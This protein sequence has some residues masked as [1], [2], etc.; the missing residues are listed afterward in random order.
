MSTLS[1]SMPTL[2]D[3]A[4]RTDPDGKI[5]A[6]AMLLSQTNEILEDCVFTEGN[7]PTGHQE[8]IQTGLPEV[9][10]RSLN[11]GI[12][13]SK[14]T[15]A[16]ITE[17]CSMLEARGEIDVK[18]AAL[19]DN[20]SSFRLSENK[21]FI[22]AMNQQMAETMFYGNPQTSPKQH[23]GLATRYSD[24]SAGNAENILD[25]G[26]TGSDNTSIYIVGW[27]N[28]TVFC[29]Y[30]KG[31]QAGLVH[32]DLG[33]QTVHKADG[34]RLQALEDLYCWDSGLCVKD[35]RYA[36]RI[37]NI[38]VSDLAA[39]TGT[40]APTAST[41]IVAL[42]EQAIDLFPELNSVR[43]VAYTNRAV[44][45]GLRSL[46]RQMSADV[47]S[48]ESGFN[49]FGRPHSTMKFQELALRKCDKILK[50]ESRVT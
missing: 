44:R 26:G 5:A 14:S 49:Q 10:Y 43:A 18:V 47:L 24:L 9:Y 50:T 31:T 1:T 37:C 36:V 46:A 17:A 38:D 13:P 28:Q 42:M 29:P 3:V 15:T 8:S 23:L 25:A 33:E 16:Q 48:I 41:N 34:T 12:P 39:T 27:G 35:W 45:S 40:Q 21:P 22:E 2:F 20:T 19:N 7:L 4:K 30:P 32:K 11:E 6:V